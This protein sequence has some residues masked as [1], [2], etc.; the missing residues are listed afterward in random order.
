MD[1]QLSMHMYKKELSYQKR[2]TKTKI[3]NQKGSLLSGN[4]KND[5]MQMSLTHTVHIRTSCYIILDSSSI[6]MDIRV[7]YV[8]GVRNQYTYVV[9]IRT[10]HIRIVYCFDFQLERTLLSFRLLP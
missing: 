7:W 1:S 8:C 2:K 6:R 5:F 4:M 10:V 3:K 9:C